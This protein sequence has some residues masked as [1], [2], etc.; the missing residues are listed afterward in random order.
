MKVIILA[1]P[2]SRVDPRY[3]APQEQE[4][5]TEDSVNAKQSYQAPK[6]NEQMSERHR[7]LKQNDVDKARRHRTETTQLKKK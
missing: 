3:R 2:P 6:S 7:K 5:T 4:E 1:A